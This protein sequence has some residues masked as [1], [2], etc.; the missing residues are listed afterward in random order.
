MAP[1][2]A[3]P[4]T[5][6]SALG[7]TDSSHATS[8]VSVAP[9]LPHTLA[10]AVLG[11]AV[12]GVGLGASVALGIA[13]AE[14]WGLDGFL[15]RLVP[16]LLVT[17]LVVPA[18]LFLRRRFDRRSLRGIGL[19][20][21]LTAVRTAGLGFAVV[22]AAA[23]VV[24]GGATVAGWLTWGAVDRGDLLLFLVTN[25]SIALLYEAVPEEVSLRGYV[26]TTL[27][28]RYARWVA[29]VVTTALFLAAAST[30]VVVGAGLTRLLDVEPFP[31]GVVPAGE[32]PVSYFM[33]LAVFGLMLAYAREADPTASVWTCVGAHL[34]FLTVNRVV[35]SVGGTGVEVELASPDVLL[36]VPLYVGLA[37]VAF[38]FLGERT[39][40]PSPR[41]VPRTA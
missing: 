40:R 37:I 39:P 23:V 5:P 34:A 18:I 9:P 1:D 21:P 28:S 16:A 33:L 17:S 27:R 29:I 30:S 26:L 15:A 31:W 24:L 11:A 25:T 20:G 7:S 13:A 32:D 35:L 41:E 14:H 4:S 38:A 19:V 10:R 8:S 36:L 12:M 2:D 6:S 22:V 3:V